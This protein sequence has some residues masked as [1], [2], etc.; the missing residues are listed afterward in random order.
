[1][2]F[3]VFK[4]FVLSNPV[5]CTVWYAL[6][7]SGMFDYLVRLLQLQQK[8]TRGRGRNR[9]RGAHRAGKRSAD[10]DDDG[11]DSGSEYG[12]PS[13]KKKARGSA[14]YSGNRSRGRGRGRG[15]RTPRSSNRLANLK[16]I[17][18]IRVADTLYKIFRPG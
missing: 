5:L 15:G 11:E 2:R 1:M 3:S 13:R 4:I 12:G 18:V 10:D 16:F 6:E 8:V 9:G 7:S 14:S 17:I